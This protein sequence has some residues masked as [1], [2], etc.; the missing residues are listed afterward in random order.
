MQPVFYKRK[1]A[2]VWRWV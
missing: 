1:I 2:Y